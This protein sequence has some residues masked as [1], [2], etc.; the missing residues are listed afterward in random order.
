MFAETGLPHKHKMRLGGGN[1]EGSFPLKWAA[2]EAAPDHL[3]GAELL[4][5]LTSQPNIIRTRLARRIY[6]ARLRCPHCLA[7]ARLPRPPRLTQKSAPTRS[8]IF[9]IMGRLEARQRHAAWLS[10]FKGQ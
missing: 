1:G 7:S 2:Q 4:L 5:K 6:C 9:E 8:E 3:P 10:P